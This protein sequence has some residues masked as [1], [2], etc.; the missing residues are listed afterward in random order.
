[1]ND[2]EKDNLFYVCSLIEFIGRITKNRRSTIVAILGKKE[3]SRQLEI[4]ETNHCLSFEQVSD[5]IIDYFNIPE[6]D[7]DSVGSCKYNVPSFLAIGKQYQRLILNVMAEENNIT[8]VLYDVF[9]SFISDE[10]SNFN[11][12]VYYSNP[13][14][15]KHSYLEGYLL[16]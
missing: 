14:Y 2:K 12:S 3:I 10:I 7:F 11:S 5:E 6:G 16:P 9:K 8:N 1:M 15:L 4:A 13:D